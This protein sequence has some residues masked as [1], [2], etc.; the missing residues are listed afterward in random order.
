MKSLQWLAFEVQV[1]CSA[2]QCLDDSALELTLH[3]HDIVVFTYVKKS[4][5]RP[6]LGFGNTQKKDG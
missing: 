3:M 2:C 5:C 6:K 1:P 4:L